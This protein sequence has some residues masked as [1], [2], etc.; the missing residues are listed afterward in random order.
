MSTP[1]DRPLDAIGLARSGILVER[2]FEFARLGRLRD[3]LAD[4]AGRAQAR[5]EFQLVGE[6]PVAALDVAAVLTLECQRCLGPMRHEIDTQSRLVFAGT[7]RAGLPEGYEPVEGDPHRID[8]AALVEDELLLGLPIIP[9][10]AQGEACTLP[11]NGRAAG[12]GG[13]ET[14]RPFAGLRD[15]LKH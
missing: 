13:T 12:Q 6:W 11:W 15:L 4:A 1:T 2:E 3:R 14:R 10:H 5:A 7:E 8:L 9:Q